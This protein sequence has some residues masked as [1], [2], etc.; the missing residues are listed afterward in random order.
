M[1]LTGTLYPTDYS[2]YEFLL[3]HPRPEVNF[4]TPSDRRRFNA[5]PF[6]PFLFKL[7]SPRNGEKT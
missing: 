4:W 6:S 1:K 7:K 2:W 5:P 3:H